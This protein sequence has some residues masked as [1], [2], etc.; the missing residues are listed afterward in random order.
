MQRG[1]HTGEGDKG[2]KISSFMEFSH[3]VYH[4]RDSPVGTAAIAGHSRAEEDSCGRESTG[5]TQAHVEQIACMIQGAREIHPFA[6]HLDEGL[7]HVPPLAALAGAVLAGTVRQEG[8]EG[9]F[10][11]PHGF[12]SEDGPS[13]WG[14][15][16]EVAQ[17]HLVAHPLQHDQADNVTRISQAIEGGARGDRPTLPLQDDG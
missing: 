4:R 8:G 17:T 10:P 7:V 13:L 1:C 15:F 5:L 6:V 9:R 16:G 11:Y 12:M 3:N 2:P 14:H